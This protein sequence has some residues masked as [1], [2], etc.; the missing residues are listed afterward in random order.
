MSIEIQKYKYN[1]LS[2]EER[3]PLFNLT[4]DKSIIIKATVIKSAVVVWD[5]D[6]YIQEAE[7]Q[8]GDKEVYEEVS[9]DP[10][11]YS[12]SSTENKKKRR[13]VS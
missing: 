11:Y 4:N 10:Q 1:N 6:D 12:Q 7:K 2:R 13:S 5:R 8:L 3:G 9:N